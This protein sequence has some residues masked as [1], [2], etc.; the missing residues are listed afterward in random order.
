MGT[1]RASNYAIAH[2]PGRREIRF[3]GP[4]SLLGPVSSLGVLP[5]S[6]TLI[7]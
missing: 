1:T 4:R 5:M 7:F 3:W 2:E 6:T